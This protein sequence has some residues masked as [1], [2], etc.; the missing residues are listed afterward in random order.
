MLRSNNLIGID[1]S[2]DLYNNKEKFIRAYDPFV[3]DQMLSGGEI[4]NVDVIDS[5]MNNN[6]A[7]D[8]TLRME[9]G[10]YKDG[11]Y[12]D[13]ICYLLTCKP[14]ADVNK[15][16]SSGFTALHTAAWTNNIDALKI[17]IDFNGDRSLTHD[18]FLTPLQQSKVNYSHCKEAAAMLEEYFPTE[19]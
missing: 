2:V 10:K 15:K 19:E 1:T 14:P 5:S 4:S 16:R 8:G 6:T 18:K 7:L 11:K 9:E 13:K 12:M 3:W 17:I